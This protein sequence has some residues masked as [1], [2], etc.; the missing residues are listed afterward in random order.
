MGVYLLADDVDP[1][2]GAVAE[3]GSLGVPVALGPRTRIRGHSWG[4]GRRERERER[5]RASEE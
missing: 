4:G 3:V 1:G 5:Q 2:G